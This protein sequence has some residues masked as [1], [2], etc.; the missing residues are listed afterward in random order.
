MNTNLKKIV[1]ACL[2]M[3]MVLSPFI[4]LSVRA[5]SYPSALYDSPSR[6]YAPYAQQGRQ[7]AMPSY[8]MPLD[9]YFPDDMGNI[10]MYV[11]V[12]GEVYKPGQHIVRQ[13]SDVSTVLSL[14][15]G[16]KEDANLKKAKIM[17]YKP[18]ENGRQVYGVNLQDYLDKGDR[19]QFVELKPSDTIVIPK[20]KGIDGNMALRIAGLIVSVASVFAIVND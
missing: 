12:L 6:S 18:D 8:G 7:Q 2:L 3:Q 11:N 17:R 4:A 14:V 15:G 13:D 19:T 5:E 9:T 16:A 1:A 20:K 10:L